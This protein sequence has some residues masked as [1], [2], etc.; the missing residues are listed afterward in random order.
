ME[1]DKYSGGFNKRQNWR[2]ACTGVDL[3]FVAVVLAILHNCLIGHFA[4]GC[5]HR[6]WEMYYKKLL[7][8]IAYANFF[9]ACFFVCADGAALLLLC[10]PLKNKYKMYKRKCAVSGVIQKT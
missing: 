5:L 6:R 4:V 8:K 2:G 1:D 9:M 7:C 3:A 10:M